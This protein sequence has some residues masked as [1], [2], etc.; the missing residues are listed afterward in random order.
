MEPIL[1]PILSYGLHL[2]PEVVSAKVRELNP[3]WP[4]DTD[5]TEVTLTGLNLQFKIPNY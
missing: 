3:N 1:S 2:R 5:Y 4:S